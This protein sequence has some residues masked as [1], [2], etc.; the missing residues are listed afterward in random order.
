MQASF[1][2]AALLVSIACR[3]Y[4]QTQAEKPAFD[5]ASIKPNNSPPGGRG[6]PVGGSVRFTEEGVAGRKA[7]VR[8]IIQAAYRLTEYQVSGAPGWLD[9]D[10]FDVE[11]KTETPA[12]KD[13]LRQM[14]QTLWRTDSNSRSIAEPG[15]C[16]FTS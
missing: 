6:G 4:A 12:N 10:T 14:L 7:T 2:C 15:K 9:S 13:Q 11:A 3:A 8:R 5:A 1:I 16:R